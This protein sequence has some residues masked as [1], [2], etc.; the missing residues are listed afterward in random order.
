MVDFWKAAAA[1]LLTVVLSLVLDKQ[2]KDYSAL[3]TVAVCTMV[4]AV[5][6]AYLS[7]VLE[8]LRELEEAARIPFV[9]ILLKVVGVGIG[10]ELTNLICADAG[11]SSLGKSMQLLGSAVILGQL[12]P[13][14]RALLAM[15]REILCT[16]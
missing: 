10:T 5:A 16:S 12:V 1:V 9:N 13:V 14:L 3:L 6:A 2:S 4:G 11:K 7:P 15:I 8:F